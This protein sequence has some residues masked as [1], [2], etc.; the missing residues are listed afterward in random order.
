MIERM[1]PAIRRRDL[2]R[3]AGIAAITVAAWS[4]RGAFAASAAGTV[5]I[6]AFTDKGEAQP[7]APVAKIVMSDADGKMAFTPDSLEF[8]RGETVRFVLHN[9]GVLDV[10]ERQGE[11]VVKARTTTNRNNRNGSNPSRRNPRISSRRCV[12]LLARYCARN[13]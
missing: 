10:E 1:N 6:V 8:K 12:C 11:I 2:L 9:K 13:S 4:G 5:T 7:P 3:G